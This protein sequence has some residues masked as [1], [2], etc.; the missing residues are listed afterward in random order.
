MSSV[1]FNLFGYIDSLTWIQ[2]TSSSLNQSSNPY[3]KCR[4]GHTLSKISFSKDPVTN[5]PYSSKSPRDGLLVYGGCAEDGSTLDDV[6]WLDFYERK[7]KELKFSN[8]IP[9]CAHSAI[10]LQVSN[11]SDPE[12]SQK[13]VIF[14]GLLKSLESDAATVYR[15]AKVMDFGNIH[16]CIGVILQ[17]TRFFLLCRIQYYIRYMLRLK[18][19]FRAIRKT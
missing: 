4:L 16:K 9:R 18:I 17:L 11:D 2:I 15:D 10:P 13:L 12:C 7:W 5:I 3:P 1:D 19:K 8:L 6:W 14:G